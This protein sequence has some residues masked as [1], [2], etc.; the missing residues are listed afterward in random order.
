MEFEED[1]ELFDLPELEEIP[2]QLSLLLSLIDSIY[3]KAEWSS[4]KTEMRNLEKRMFSHLMDITDTYDGEIDFSLA[5]VIFIMFRSVGLKP[6]NQYNFYFESG[7]LRCNNCINYHQKEAHLELKE[8]D[9]DDATIGDIIIDFIRGIP[10]E[11]TKQSKALSPSEND[12][13]S[14][15]F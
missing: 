6:K 14:N 11:E 7:M 13:F 15:P 9:I 3:E 2:N 10:L 1:P 5:G 4:N 8:S 12:E